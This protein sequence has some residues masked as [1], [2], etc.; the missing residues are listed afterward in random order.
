VAG[1]QEKVRMDRLIQ[2][3]SNGRKDETLIRA[4]AEC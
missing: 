4:G 2:G 1:I 3:M